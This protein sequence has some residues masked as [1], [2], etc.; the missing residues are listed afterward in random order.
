MP[1]RVVYYLY[2]LIF[3]VRL[4]KFS[5]YENCQSILEWEKIHPDFFSH[6]N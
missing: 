4:V 5:T 3:M 1:L 2:I 6:Q